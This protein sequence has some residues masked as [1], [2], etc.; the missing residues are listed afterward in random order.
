MQL[1]QSPHAPSL[2]STRVLLART[3][4]AADDV[5]GAISKRLEPVLDPCAPGAHYLCYRLYS[6]CI[7]QTPRTFTRQRFSRKAHIV[8]PMLQLV[9]SPSA[10][11]PLLDPVFLGGTYCAND[12]ASCAVSELLGPLLDPGSPGRHKLCRRCCSWCSL[13]LD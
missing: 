13:K 5:A 6:L 1:I 10:F 2:S 3:T 7:L 11:W 8:P 12:A 9:Q 4:C